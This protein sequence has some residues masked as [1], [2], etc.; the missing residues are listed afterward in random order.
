MET[1]LSTAYMP[2]I[3]YIRAIAQNEKVYLEQYENFS[4]QTW[5][6]RCK[7]FTA[8]GSM[9]LSIPV[10]KGGEKHLIKDT[11]ISY[12]ENWQK[13]HWNAIV[14]AYNSSPFFEYFRDDFEPYYSKKYEFLLDYNLNSLNTILNLLE[15]K[16][17]I[18]LTSDFVND[19][20]ENYSDLRNDIHPK[21]SPATNSIFYKSTPYP[22][23]FDNIFKFEPDLSILDILFNI[24]FEAADYVKN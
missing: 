19:N 5:R 18:V 9:M 17:D 1:L 12:N 8:A 10:V 24:G 20:D 3:Q 23:T 11:K 14:S 22:Q 2:N 21:K 7:I 4:K 13:K 15:I 6:N 16:T